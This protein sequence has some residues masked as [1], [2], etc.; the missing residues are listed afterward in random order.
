MWKL[1]I[2]EYRELVRHDDVYS[3]Q[4]RE[5]RAFLFNCWLLWG[6]SIPQCDCD[7]WASHHDA[8]QYGYGDDYEEWLRAPIAAKRN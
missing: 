2:D 3:P 7:C 5:L 4:T 1:I 8:Y 6:P